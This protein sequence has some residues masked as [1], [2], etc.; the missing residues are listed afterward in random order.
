LIWV[1]ARA[2]M[3]VRG[4]VAGGCV[5]SHLQVVQRSGVVAHWVRAV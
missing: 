1:W 2:F 4:F 3:C 5:S